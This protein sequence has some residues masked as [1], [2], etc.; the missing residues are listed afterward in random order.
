MRHEPFDFRDSHEDTCPHCGRGYER[1]PQTG[2]WECF[3]CHI[4]PEEG[5]KEWKDIDENNHYRYPPDYSFPYHEDEEDRMNPQ[6]H[7]CYLQND[8]WDYWHLYVKFGED[9]GIR[10]NHYPLNE[11]MDLG[12]ISEES[13]G[14]ERMQELCLERTRAGD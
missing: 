13:N 8:C 3:R 4:T 1:D 12:R 9:V 5:N 6:C 2:A 10:C 14:E 7:G 11:E